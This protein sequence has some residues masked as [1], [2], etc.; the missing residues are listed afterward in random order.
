MSQFIHIPVEKIHPHPDNPRKDLGDLTELADSIRQNGVMQN[1][2][3]VPD[4]NGEYIAVIG[5][6]RHAAAQLA[7]L[8]EVPCMVV[9]MTPKEQ[10]QRMLVE[11]MQRSDLTIYEQAQGFQMMLDMGETVESVATSSGFSTTT[12]RNRVKLTKL[13][14]VAFRESQERGATLQDYMELDKISDLDLKN[15]VLESI[16]TPNFSNTLK[17]ALQIENTRRFVAERIA[18]VQGWATEIE[19][20]DPDLAFVSSFCI[21]NWKKTSVVKK[22]ADA[23]TIPY[24]YLVHSVGIDIYMRKADQ[25][26]TE[27]ARRRMMEANARERMEMELDAIATRHFELRLDFVANFRATKKYIADICLFAAQSCVMRGCNWPNTEIYE[28]LLGMEKQLPEQA[29]NCREKLWPYISQTDKTSEYVLLVTAYAQIDSAR[30][31][32]FSQNWNMDRQEFEFVY[33][34]NEALKQLYEF[35]TAIGYEMSAEELEM[36]NGTHKLLVSAINGDWKKP[37]TQGIEEDV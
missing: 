21:Y 19:Q 28:K 6:R 2:T 9:E 34:P 8:A 27:E 31:R 13:D 14:P 12:I 36:Q 24:F 29:R 30:Q 15:K 37:A 25:K 4:G 10:V 20:R 17:Q 11:N 16:G 1:L 32:F 3:V 7:G 35:L 33:K 26:E 22:P 23:G 18:D 5:H